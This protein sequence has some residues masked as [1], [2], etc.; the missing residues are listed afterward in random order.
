MSFFFAKE[1]GLNIAQNGLWKRRKWRMKKH[2]VEMGT[3]LMLGQST[4][5]CSSWDPKAPLLMSPHPFGQ[6][7]NFPVHRFQRRLESVFTLSFPLCQWAAFGHTE[8]WVETTCA[9][10]L[11]DQCLKSQSRSTGMGSYRRPT[12][13]VGS[14]LFNLILLGEWLRKEAP[15]TKGVYGW[16]VPRG[17]CF[18][19]D[20]DKGI[21][22]LI[23]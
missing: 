1:L 10:H 20:S 13:E 6:S 9:S 14:S 16:S 15:R 19:E 4:V 11:Q 17:S 18:A 8:V 22:N 21:Y 2:P 12:T 23:V 7:Q 3:S 5:L